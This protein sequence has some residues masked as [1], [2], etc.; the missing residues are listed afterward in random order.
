M[1]ISLI[2]KTVNIATKHLFKNLNYRYGFLLDFQLCP[3]KDVN[4]LDNV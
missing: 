2:G 3:Q 1:V 4:E